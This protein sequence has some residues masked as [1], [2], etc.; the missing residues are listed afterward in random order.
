MEV[1]GWVAVKDPK[2]TWS[3]PGRQG[4]ADEGQTRESLGCRPGWQ[5]EAKAPRQ[6]HWQDNQR[7]GRN[8]EGTARPRQSSAPLECRHKAQHC[9]HHDQNHQVCLEV[10]ASPNYLDKNSDALGDK[11][12]RKD[13]QGLS[14]RLAIEPQQAR[15]GKDG[16]ERSDPIPAAVPSHTSHRDE[17]RRGSDLSAAERAGNDDGH[18]NQEDDPKQ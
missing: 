10:G 6:R 17:T 18:S 12:W 5:Q 16:R 3:I 4:Y 2:D 8:D 13:N 9:R 11:E 14:Q 7:S 15:Q 1:M